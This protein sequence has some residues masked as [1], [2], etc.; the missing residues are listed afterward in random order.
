M[1]KVTDQFTKRENEV[2][3]F[4]TLNPFASN[5]EIAAHFYIS[6][7]T[8]GMHLRSMYKK[9]GVSGNKARYQMLQKQG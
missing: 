4:L 6:Q 5:K 9:V 2:F 7:N 8:L 3:Q 1:T